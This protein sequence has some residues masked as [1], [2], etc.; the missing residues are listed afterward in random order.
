MKWLLLLVVIGLAFLAYSQQ[1]S[2]D[3]TKAE[4][5]LALKKIEQLESRPVPTPSPVAHQNPPP[6]GAPAAAVPPANQWMWGRGDNPLE[7]GPQGTQGG[8]H[9]GGKGRK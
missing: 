2:L 9:V 8:G 1:Q 6:P 3:A 7:A 4:L 5:A